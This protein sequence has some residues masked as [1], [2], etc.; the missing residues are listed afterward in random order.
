MCV[1]VCVF[2]LHI[3]IPMF[4]FH[5]YLF[6]WFVHET[7]CC[8]LANANPSKPCQ[9][10]IA[11]IAQVDTWMFCLF[12]FS[13]T[14]VIMAKWNKWLNV[15]GKRN[16]PI[17]VNVIICMPIYNIDQ[18]FHKKYISICC[19]NMY[20]HCFHVARSNLATRVCVMTS[21]EFIFVWY[22]R[23]KK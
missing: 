17:M 23:F 4:A 19:S 12:V 11:C 9:Y 2:L 18:K 22:I 16:I 14:L 21:I 20:L 10:N 15:Y 8:I 3:L 7:T 5:V 1:C 6:V 13:I